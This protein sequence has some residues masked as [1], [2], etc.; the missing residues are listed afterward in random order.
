LTVEPEWAMLSFLPT[1]Y[2]ASGYGDGR[3]VLQNV[4]DQS[5]VTMQLTNP[6]GTFQP[7]AITVALSSD[8]D[9]VYVGAQGASAFDRAAGREVAT[10]DDTQIGGI[11]TSSDGAIVATLFDGTIELLDPELRVI[12]SVPGARG[13]VADLRFSGDGRLLAARGN[14][15]TVSLYDV[16]S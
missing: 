12:A 10:N 5:V 2:V 7:T 8:E 11:F 14:D 4:E 6:T 1:G 15:D 16:T 9:V 13:W 3:V